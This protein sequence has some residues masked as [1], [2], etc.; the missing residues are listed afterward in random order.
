MQSTENLLQ[1]MA[2]EAYK[3]PATPDDDEVHRKLFEDMCRRTQGRFEL[4]A[5]CINYGKQ[6][7]HKKTA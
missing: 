7:H 3:V 1:K 5:V 6:I 2:E 4:K